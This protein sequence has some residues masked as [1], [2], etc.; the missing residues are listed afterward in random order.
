M[1]EQDT[2][3]V[4]RAVSLMESLFSPGLNIIFPGAQPSV[5]LRT[6]ESYP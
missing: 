4:T 1:L 2:L 3:G 5:I 6:A